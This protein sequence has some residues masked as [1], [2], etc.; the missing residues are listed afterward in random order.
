MRCVPTV[1]FLAGVLAALLAPALAADPGPSPY[2]GDEA[3]RIKAL[4]DQE[5]ADLR[6]G[7]GMGYARA[8]ELNGYPG[9]RHVL[10]MAGALGLAPDQAAAAE[11]LFRAMRR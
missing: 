10:D 3:R 7:R 6:R 1:L 8:A 4:S 9:P 11:T 5:I 2:A